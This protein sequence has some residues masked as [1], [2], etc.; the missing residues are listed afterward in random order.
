MLFIERSLQIL[1]PEGRV[2]IITSNKWMRAAYGDIFRDYLLK[3][4]KPELLL[5]FGGVKIFDEATVDTS[6]IFTR[7]VKQAKISFDAV[8]FDNSFNPDEDDIS[9]YTVKN[10]IILSGLSS[11]SWNIA[12]D[13]TNDIKNKI[14]DKGTF[15]ENWG[16]SINYGIKTGFNDAFFI[17]SKIKAE[18]IAQDPKSDEIIEPF[19]RGRDVHKY[20]IDDK[21][22]FLINTYNGKLIDEE[23]PNTGKKIKVRVERIDVENQ[24]P[25]IY[26]YLLNFKDKL[27]ERTDQ[28]EH[29]TNHR[30]CAYQHLF[31]GEK[32]IYPETTVRRSEFF[33]DKN[34]FLT[35]KTCFILTGVNLKYLNG[36]LC[37]KVVEYYL[38][39][40]LRTL[41]KTSIQYSKQYM[42]KLPIPEITDDN[43][44]TVTQIETLVNEIIE[45]KEKVKT[46]DITEQTDKIDKLVY[47]LYDLTNEEIEII[48]K[49]IK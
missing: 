23:N 4:S 42:E 36:V 37:S 32:I 31:Y 11:E 49:Q 30:N 44:E 7:K 24:Y 33:F 26:N 39:T 1:K 28:G 19:L 48:E 18:L 10:K 27:I 15:L 17:D 14:K 22:Q 40:E 3:N 45:L 16:I 20:Y 41:G 34:K 38:E 46:A 13:S 29:W 43:K 9:E 25:A 47:E 35:D 21:V 6:I 5:D 8:Y 12:T 2:C